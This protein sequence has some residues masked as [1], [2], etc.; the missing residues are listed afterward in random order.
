MDNHVVRNTLEGLDELGQGHGVLIV[1]KGSGLGLCGSTPSSA[2]AAPGP[3][4]HF[5]TAPARL[6][7]RCPSCM[8]FLDDQEALPDFVIFT[9]ATH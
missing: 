7:R 9:L 8:V 5:P 6:S 1:T 4:P 2:A 3:G